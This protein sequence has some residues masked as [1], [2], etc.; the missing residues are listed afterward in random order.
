MIRPEVKS[1]LTILRLSSDNDLIISKIKN[2]KKIID[3]TEFKLI[4]NGDKPIYLNSMTY[5]LVSSYNCWSLKSQ[6]EY[7][8]FV[9]NNTSL[10]SLYQYVKS[11]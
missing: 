7:E 3:N 5:N 6:I 10:N 2:V 4:I 8:I 1:L 11:I 9:K